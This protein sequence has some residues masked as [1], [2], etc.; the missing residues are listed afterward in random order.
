[1]ID[2][3]KLLVEQ[4]VNYPEMQPQDAVKLLY[5]KN[6]GCGH[7]LSNNADYA[8]FI[9][10]E[11][12][13]LQEPIGW[14]SENIGIYSRL[15]LPSPPDRVFSS[16]LAKLFLK[17]GDLPHEMSGFLADLEILKRL[18]A[19]NRFSFS[20]E[21]VDDYLKQYSE[22]GYPVVSHSAQYKQHYF[23]A[24]RVIKTE[25]VPFIDFLIRLEGLILKK[26][27]AVIAI[28]GGS[29]TGK[30]QLSRLLHELYD[31]NI[32]HT[33]DFFLPLDM[34]TNER[35]SEPGGN[36]HYERIE[37]EIGRKLSYVNEFSYSVYD[38]SV[39][40][41]VGERAI[42]PNRLTVVEGA[43][44]THCNNHIQYDFCVFLESD[45]ETRIRRIEKRNGGAML[46]RFIKEWIPMEEK[47][48]EH[49]G[50]RDRCD[51]IIGT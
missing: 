7:M 1:M 26:S 50:V 23:P 22:N 24:Y 30:S 46:Q 51:M 25:Y 34:R 48:F 2:A 19:G 45:Y 36:V 38:C 49:F 4:V 28:E 11:S 39:N 18:A 14:R 9:Y 37:Q 16:V 42:R 12:S 47:Y 44:S 10:A 33:D 5:Q 3:S 35:F 27:D 17:S 13:S 15:Y 31:C 40:E 43:Y 8:E 21:T 29:A 41:C 32:I 20:A 6:F